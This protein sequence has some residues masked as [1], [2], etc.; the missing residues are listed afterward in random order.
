MSESIRGADERLKWFLKVIEGAGGEV[1]STESRHNPINIFCEDRDSGDDTFNISEAAG[2]TQTSHDTSFD[3]STTRITDKGRA[4]LSTLAAEV[5]PTDWAARVVDIR[6]EGA[7]F[8]AACSG[9]QESVD[10]YVSPKDYPYSAAFGC[11]PGGGC[12]ECGGLGVKW[13]TADY[14]A[15]ATSMLADMA[16]EEAGEIDLYDDKVQAGIDW[17]MRQWG[18]TLGLQTWTRGDGSESVE[19]DVGAEIHTIL[20]D[21]GLRDPETNEMAALRAQPQASANDQLTADEAW[22]DLLDKDDRTSPEDQP[23]MCLITAGELADYMAR[24]Q[25]QAREDAQPV[26][27]LRAVDEEMVCA[28]LGIA[29]AGDSYETAKKKLASLI[30]W[31]IAVATDP[32]VG[33]H[34]APD[35]LRAIEMLRA[36]EGDSVTIL[37]NNPEATDLDDAMAVV[38][39]GPWTD[40]KDR[41]FYGR[42]VS[43]AL[44]KALAAL[45]AEQKGG[46]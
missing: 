3:T 40:W 15:M 25:P 18:E 32:R 33:G 20:V 14:D 4:Y 45:Q 24:A 34:P 5:E 8:W 6:E 35:A 11:Q 13:D 37:C 9:C 46:A 44:S 19:G 10:G 1:C 16:A 2:Y 22:S 36:S 17:T 21:A 39:C 7:G 23:E 38:C 28:H 43:D 31:N 26:G 29:D 42:D 27:W 41:R 12:S 30:Q